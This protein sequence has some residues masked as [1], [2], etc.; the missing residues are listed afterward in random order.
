[1]QRVAKI[2]GDEVGES[3]LELLVI[4]AIENE[5][6]VPV[7]IETDITRPTCA[8]TG[9]TCLPKAYI[10]TQYALFRL[11]SGSETRNSSIAWALF[12][13]A[14]APASMNRSAP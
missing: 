8:S 4:E 10:I 1:M 13:S 2:G 7:E 11:S 14:K 6:S 12:I 3:S 9:R 5:A